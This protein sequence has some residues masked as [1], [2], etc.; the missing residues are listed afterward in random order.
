MFGIRANNAQMSLAFYHFTIG[1][2]FFN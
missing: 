1:A 2:D